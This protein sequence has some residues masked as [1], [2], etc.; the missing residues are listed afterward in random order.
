MQAKGDAKQNLDDDDDGE[1][2]DM[3]EFEQSGMLDKEDPVILDYL[4]CFSSHRSTF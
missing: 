1:A 2:M 3:E 4:L